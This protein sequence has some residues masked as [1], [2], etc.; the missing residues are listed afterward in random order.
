MNDN[1]T[2]PSL[3]PF[4]VLDLDGVPSETAVIPSLLAAS[5]LPSPLSLLPPAFSRAGANTSPTDIQTSLGADALTGLGDGG[6][7][8]LPSVDPD[9]YSAST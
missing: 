6:P 3:T 4:T 8:L 7:T 1:V 5:A 2:V 9:D